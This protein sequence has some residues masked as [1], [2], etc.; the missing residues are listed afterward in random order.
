MKFFVLFLLSLTTLFAEFSF[1]GSVGLDSQAY[2]SAPSQKHKQNFTAVQE[3]E[4][5]Y[6]KDDLTLY[7]KLYA[8][9][10]SYDLSSDDAKK[11]ERTFARLD[12]LYL[13]Y[14]F[15][16]DMLQAGKSIKFWGSLEVRNIV[17]GFNPRDLRQDMFNADK[18]GVYNISYSH[19]TQSGE[20]SLIVKL[21]EVDQPMAAQPYVYY[22]FPYFVSYDGR[23][24]EAQDSY[25]PSIFLTYSGSTD[26]E[27]ALDYAFIYQNGYDSQRYFITDTPQNLNPTSPTFTDPTEFKQYAYIANKFMT[28]N[29][30]VVGATLIK[31]EA[32]YAK[33]DDNV[34]IGDYSHIALGVEHTIENLMGSEAGL[35]LLVEYY[36]Y[37]TYE[38]DKYTDLELFETMQNDLFLGFRYSVNNANETSLLG[39]VIADVV[40]NEQ[41]YFCKFDT[42]VYDSFKVQADYY[43]INPSK[44]ETLSLPTAYQFLGKHQRVGLNIAWYF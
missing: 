37:D 1:S 18:F 16:N 30:L 36:R 29:T 8:Q 14:D 40:Y 15:E 33:V 2:L 22:F 44:K 41:S 7:S 23:L 6:I 28:Y 17:D 34:Y 26:T 10:D 13:K 24:H 3:L 4:L 9:E 43:Y 31:L 11:N 12:E 25:R 35:G 27:Y 39:G 20:L 38:D 32:L 42:R 19:Y 21:D 5:K